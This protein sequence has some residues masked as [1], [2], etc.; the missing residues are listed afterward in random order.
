MKDQ[1][2]G[3]INDYRKYGLLRAI[4]AASALSVTVCWLRTAAGGVGTASF[5]RN[6]L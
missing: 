6:L 1:Y 4:T 2:F 5:A 3:D